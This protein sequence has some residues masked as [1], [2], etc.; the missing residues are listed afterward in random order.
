[1]STEKGAVAPVFT[2]D[3]LMKIAIIDNGEK[4]VNLS[5]A[6]DKFIIEIEETSRKL[7]NLPENTCYSRETVARMLVSAQGT[8]PNGMRFKIIDSYRPMSAQRQIW[9]QYFDD[10]KRQHSDWDDEEVAK[11]TDRWVANPRV[12]P[13]HTTGG[14]LD[15][16]VADEHDN[17]L[18]MGTPVNSADEK[19]YM[20]SE[21]VT[22]KAKENRN[23][24]IKVMTD[25]GFVGNPRE[26]WHWSYGDRRWAGAM[27]K[28][29]A[30]YDGR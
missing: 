23:M 13:P 1:M 14:A 5:D 29:N 25:A 17:E 28:S 4:L 7:Q 21:K 8:L 19:S 2:N 27:K 24:L 16:T 9:Q 10:F 12:V 26:W 22:G 15:L 18:D 30:L 11:E 3:E 6:S 20:L